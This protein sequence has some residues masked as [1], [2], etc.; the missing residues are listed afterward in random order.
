[1]DV[2]TQVEA[3]RSRV[4]A[5]PLRER[6]VLTVT[7]A[8][9]VSWLNGLLTCDLA[10]ASPRDARYG[11]FV[12]RNGR[13][14]ADAVV[15]VE[16]G[17]VLVSVP[18]RTVEA[19]RKHLDHYLVMEDAE[20]A[21]R[22]DAF[23]VWEL[24]GPRAEAVLAAALAAGASGASIDRAGV[25]GAVVFLPCAGATDGATEAT[26]ALATSVAAEGGA[27]GDAAGW[28]ALRLERAV[29]EYGAD[30]DET[31]YPQE[32]LLEKVAVAFDKGCYLGQEVVCMLEMRGHVKRHLAALVFDGA[33]PSPAGAEVTDDAGA[34]AGT[35]TSSA[36]SPTLGRAVALAMLK[37]THAEVGRELHVG[38]AKARVV[39]RPA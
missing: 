2:K 26:G 9:R 7:G 3:A 15:V 33:E 30:F 38:A 13:I 39:D 20:I 14:L 32:A 27:V 25:G 16:E 10:K 22:A 31:T 1:M 8:D 11:L 36:T 35:I 37:R 12:G 29:P 23:A 19:L 5:V 17:R 6:V 18:A 34:P 28:Q 21:P 4:L 24:S